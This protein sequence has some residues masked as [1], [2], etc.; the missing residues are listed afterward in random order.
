[1]GAMI[2]FPINKERRM[3]RM[4]TFPLGA[5]VVWGLVSGAR[6]AETSALRA[7][8]DPVPEDA[9]FASV[10]GSQAIPRMKYP[11]PIIGAKVHPE[12][13]H[14]TPS[15]ELIFP[16]GAPWD[17]PCV[18]ALIGPGGEEGSGAA[19]PALPP[20]DGVTSRLVEGYMPGIENA[21]TMGDLEV[22]EL[23]F[24]TEGKRYESVD[25]RE[26]LIAMVRFS[27]TNRAASPREVVVAIQFGQARPGLSVK[28]PPPVYPEPLSFEAPFVRRADGAC[29]ACLLAGGRKA[30]FKSLPPGPDPSSYT[31]LNGRAETVRSPEFAVDVER[32]GEAV[33]V[34]TWQSPTGADLYVESSRTHS[35][36][37]AVDVEAV[38]PDGRAT[39]VGGLYRTGF[40]A[41]ARPAAEAIAPGGHSA[42]LPWAELAKA[43]PQGRSKLVARCRFP[44]GAGWQPVSSWEPIF[45]FA[46]PGVTPRFKA[47]GSIRSDENR[48]RLELALGANESAAVDLAVPYDP[49]P[50]GS[51]GALAAM[52]IDDELAGFRSYWSRELNRRAE[53]IVPEP[54]IRDGYRACVANNLLLTDRD[55][56]TGILMPHPDATAYEAVW[57]GDGSVA[58]QA[59]D[60]AGYHEEAEGMLDYF[61]SR[62]GQAK[63]EGDVASAEGFFSGDVGLR[64]MNQNGFV[65]WAMSEHY[66]LTR[67]EGWLRRVA[68]QL[69]K[70]CDWISRERARTKTMDGGR[71]PRHYGLL[72]KGRPSDLSIWDH[73]YWTDAYSY[74][75]LRGTADVLAAIG[76]KDEA[77]RLA[78]EAD[79]YKA[80]ILDSIDRSMDPAVKPPFVPP[81]PYRT[82]PP[83]R[84]FFDENWY[85]ICSPIYMVEAG[86]LDA[87]G[88]KA[89]GIDSWL[90]RHGM[91]TGL[92]AFG[93]GTID[94]YYVYNQSLAQLLRGEAAKFVWTLY[95][96]SAYAMGEGTYCTIEGHNL[97]T[98]F[99]SEAWDA[100]RQPH[101][102]SNSRYI[103]LVRI[104][105]LLEEGDVLHLLAGAPRG[106]LADGQGI[107]VRRA[108]S[109]FGEVNFKARSRADAGEVAFE[110]GPP[111]WAS[112]EVVLH[113]RPPARYG[114]IREVTVNG[115]PWKDFEGEAVKLGRIRRP[116]EAVCRLEGGAGSTR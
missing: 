44:S 105:L 98:G 18:A 17:G 6:G 28:E 73:W 9:S 11:V 90:E 56:K 68:P 104:A 10:V 69:V 33:A 2:T 64:W 62:Q 7:Y 34:G 99:N 115:Q 96:I 36:P 108:P 93:I 41:G 81:T 75:G 79:D 12:E 48:L 100:N 88:E 84:E 61:L 95:S 87:R 30:S 55:A 63:P 32:R 1:M 4:K 24:A 91:Y 21:W 26:P 23:A 80:C 14:V 82:G 29:V 58:I 86:I 66:K 94:P 38:G 43:L 102:H 60:R 13:I 52:R 74:M 47:P 71:K 85:T 111:G 101:M 97:V 76:M 25:G 15:G 78:A 77:A 31:M 8:P 113:V 70:G 22:R 67:N 39:P 45:V 92:P 65:L 49:L 37:I 106:W 89:G 59:M 83:S 109:Y 57:A 114:R 46:R 3:R 72:P 20:A 42:A 110:I 112:P 51:E 107:E 116:T 103:D 19:A 40:S 5:A 16:R 54:A 50:R 35:V 27:V 53:F